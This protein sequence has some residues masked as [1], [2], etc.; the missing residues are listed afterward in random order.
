[1]ARRSVRKYSRKKRFYKRRKRYSRKRPNYKMT[2]RLPFPNTKIYKTRYFESNLTI[3]NTLGVPNGHIFRINNLFDL[4]ATGVGHQPIAF[5]QMALLYKKYRVTGAKITIRAE[6]TATVPM[7][8]VLHQRRDGTAVPDVGQLIENGNCKY[9]TLAPTLTP[10][11]MKTITHYF[12]AKKF[13]GDDWKGHQHAAD[14]NTSP[15]QQ[16]YEH[17]ITQPTDDTSG[18]TV[19]FSITIDL[20]SIV[21]EP[22]VLAQS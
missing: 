19:R 2:K 5:D 4:D 21:S 12:S 16:C 15:I 3:T 22:V 10:G 7:L 9:T 11:S 8:M 18:G 14:F 13:F 1:M 17:I 6:N 20:I